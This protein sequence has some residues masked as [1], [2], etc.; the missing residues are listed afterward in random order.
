MTPTMLMLVSGALFLVATV[1]A[2]ITFCV[3]VKRS[4]ELVPD[5]DKVFYGFVAFMLF[6]VFAMFSGWTAVGGFVWFIAVKLAG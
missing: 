5:D 1:V 2:V 3:T 6:S 4:N